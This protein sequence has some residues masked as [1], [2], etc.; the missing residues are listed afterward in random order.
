M[1]S[2]R[3]HEEAGGGLKR[4]FRPLIRVRPLIR[5]RGAGGGSAAREHGAPTLPV[6]APWWRGVVGGVVR[7]LA[8]VRRGGA[9]ES[10][11]SGRVGVAD[12][13]PRPGEVRRPIG[14]GKPL[15]GAG[16]GRR[17]GGLGVVSRSLGA[18][19][20]V[21]QTV[22][23]SSAG[24]VDPAGPG[25]EFAR[26]SSPVPG[27]IGAPTGSGLGVRS[28]AGSAGVAGLRQGS[29]ISS[30][31]SGSVGAPTGLSRGLAARLSPEPASRA[32][33][34]GMPLGMAVESSTV[35]RGDGSAVGSGEPASVS[36]HTGVSHGAGIRSSTVSDGAESGR[37]GTG[38]TAGDSAARGMV[39]RSVSGRGLIA[40]AASAPVHGAEAV[41]GESVSVP[42]GSRA[43]SAAPASSPEQRWRA[44]VKARPLEAPRAFPVN[45]RPLVARY[46]GD[47][48]ASYTTGPATRDALTQAGA[49]GA[50]TGSVVHLPGAPA[51]AMSAELTGVLAHELT[52]AR[53]PVGRPRF[54]LRA[55]SGAMDADE[56][57][58]HTVGQQAA[59]GRGFSASQ[60]GSAPV[61]HRS[62]SSLTSAGGAAI[63]PPGSV[64]PGL[65]DQLP[66]GGASGNAVSEARTAGEGFASHATGN[67]AT[68]HGLLAALAAADPSGAAGLAGAAAV[69]G[70]AGS[71]AEGELADAGHHAAGAVSPSAVAGHGA[72]AGAGAGTTAAASAARP[73]SDIDVERIIEAVEQRLLRQ[74]ERRGGRYAG[75]F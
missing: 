53:Q 41:T 5:P 60:G 28:G 75:V 51:A 1:A 68:T 37:S 71:A 64:T 18:V 16:T 20:P 33:R 73:A 48:A 19:R 58:A 14:P 22:A 56:R 7:R 50:T 13:A 54:L 57:A 46:A 45:L 63:P 9:G 23:G 66:V 34:S 31:M 42:A 55:H 69:A 32:L 36:A 62:I 30:A 74:L 39:S 26:R 11:A 70:A 24:P 61:V 47:S 12:E 3:G 17:T 52:H 44:A 6:R 49:L 2:R 27:S 21:Q 38:P 67:D 72:G 10:S 15:I 4:L 59:A 40:R 35:S 29:A 25:H 65:V 43:V 8:M